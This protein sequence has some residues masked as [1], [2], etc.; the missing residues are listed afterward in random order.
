MNRYEMYPGLLVTVPKDA[1][2]PGVWKVIKVNPKNV[3]IL[4]E[5]GK[6]IFGTPNN[7]EPAGPGATFAP[8]TEADSRMSEGAVVKWAQHPETLFVITKLN[9]DTT[10]RLSQLGGHPERR[11]YRTVSLV[12]LQY[13]HPSKISLA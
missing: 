12:A 13:V 2:F 7:F 9:S 6:I 4:S 1:R 11:F 5:S 8:A 10:A 3:K